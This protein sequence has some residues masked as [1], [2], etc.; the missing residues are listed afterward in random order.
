VASLQVLAG[1]VWWYLAIARSIMRGSPEGDAFCGVSVRLLVF[2]A[3]SGVV[4]EHLGAQVRRA[5]VF[6]CLY[7]AQTCVLLIPL[8]SISFPRV[9]ERWNGRP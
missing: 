8:G 4:L 6:L 5:F 3:V 1:G 2:I 7:S 9:V